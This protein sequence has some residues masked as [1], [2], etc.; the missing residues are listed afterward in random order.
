MVNISMKADNRYAI[1][2]SIYNQYIDNDNRYEISH[3]PYAKS[4]IERLSNRHDDIFGWF[5]RRLEY[6]A[7]SADFRIFSDIGEIVE[8]FLVAAAGKWDILEA[9]ST[10]F[11]IMSCWISWACDMGAPRFS[12]DSTSIS[13][14]S[15]FVATLG[16]GRIQWIS[17][18]YSLTRHGRPVFCSI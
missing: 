15:L 7:S 5:F 14:R 16:C 2:Y 17:C 18:R 13:Y 12:V 6:E 9:V 4:Q 1:S 3:L 8:Q 10:R 11:L